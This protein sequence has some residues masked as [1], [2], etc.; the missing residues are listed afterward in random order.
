MNQN[1]KRKGLMISVALIALVLACGLLW[2]TFG[3]KKPITQGDGTEKT[4][5]VEVIHT[6]GTKK[7]FSYTSDQEFLGDVLVE[8]GLIEGD[9]GEYGL[10]VTSVDGEASDFA[11][12]GTWWMLSVNGTQA[13]VGV[14][15]VPVEDGAVYTWSCTDQ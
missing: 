6:D 12:D 2:M 10:F 15:E 11:K 5:E 13:P 1:S 8:E 3:M 14:S 4:F 9:E 7:S